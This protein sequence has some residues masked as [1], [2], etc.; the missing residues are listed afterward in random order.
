M[1]ILT[2]PERLSLMTS[3]QRI[4]SLQF[5]LDDLQAVRDSLTEAQTDHQAVTGAILSSRSL[6]PTTKI[7]VINISTGEV[8]FI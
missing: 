5:T 2:A 7:K 1:A 8:E 6:P 3:L 4:R